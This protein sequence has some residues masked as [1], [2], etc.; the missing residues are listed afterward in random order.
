[1]YGRFKRA[2]QMR[3]W[4]EPWLKQDGAFDTFYRRL[5]FDVHVHDEDSLEL[6]VKKAGR[7]QLVYGTNFGGWDSGASATGGH[8]DLGDL[9]PT[10]DA[11]ATRL[12]RL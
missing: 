5:F 11:N 4:S 10:L 8:V 7:S 12:L 9:V 3:P 1:M 6:L 2:T